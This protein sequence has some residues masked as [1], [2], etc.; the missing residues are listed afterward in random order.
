MSFGIPPLPPCGTDSGLDDQAR[1]LTIRLLR[2]GWGAPYR[3]WFVVEPQFA[4]SS[5]LM[6][7][8]SSLP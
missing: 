8:D 5:S 3:A 7:R 4:S 6:R 2:G 1:Q